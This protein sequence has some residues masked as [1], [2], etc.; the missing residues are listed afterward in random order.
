MSETLA[1]RVRI[2]GPRSWT[3]VLRVA[4]GVSR[5]VGQAH[6]RK[7][8][9]GAITPANIV[10]VPGE[11]ARAL[12]VELGAARPSLAA[13]L[14]WSALEAF[15]GRSGPSP[16]ADV[17]AFGLVVFYALTGHGLWSSVDPLRGVVT[18]PVR[19]VEEMKSPPLASERA[20]SFPRLSL[21]G[22]FDAWLARCVA[23]DAAARFATAPRAAR[24]LAEVSPMRGLARAASREGLAQAWQMAER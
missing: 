13:P 14:A 8:G 17:A 19:L 18:D 21:P 12:R 15:V 10:C 16:A 24:A 2:R 9:H 23:P 7:Q 22:D 1:D 6:L 5:A 11:G 20:A 4:Q 3:E